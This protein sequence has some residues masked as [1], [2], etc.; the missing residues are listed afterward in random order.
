MKVI[1]AIDFVIEVHGEGNSVQALVANATPEAAG[2]V[3]IAHLLQNHFHDQ[4]PA[5]GTFFRRLLKAR[6]LKFKRYTYQYKSY[7][8]FYFLNI[9]I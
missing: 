6:I 4:M 5:N 3:E 1:D 9:T 7:E 8:V 2:V